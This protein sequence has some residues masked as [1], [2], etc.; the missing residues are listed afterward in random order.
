MHDR[1]NTEVQRDLT[2]RLSSDFKTQLTKSSIKSATEFNGSTSVG[3]ILLILCEAVAT[4]TRQLRVSF[5]QE[6]AS[7]SFSVGYCSNCT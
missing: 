4:V 3:V 1:N 5:V 7:Y 2:Y 6:G